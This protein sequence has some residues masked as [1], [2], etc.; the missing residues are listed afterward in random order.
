MAV[1][2]VVLAGGSGTRLWPLSRELY[3]KQFLKL[4]GEHSLLQSTLARLVGIDHLPPYLVCNDEHRFLA[5]EQCRAIGVRWGAILLEPKGR[6][7]APAIALAA[8]QAVRDDADPTLLVLP[9]DHVI[10]DA[11][12]FRRSVQTGA[13]LVDGDALLTFGVVPDHAETGYGYIRAGAAVGAGHRVAEFVEKPDAETAAR[14]VA[15]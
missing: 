13:E 14:Y 6:S 2:P 10:L 11:A 4:A 7:T 9:A 15:S 8:L 1:L 5:A 12:A 3:P